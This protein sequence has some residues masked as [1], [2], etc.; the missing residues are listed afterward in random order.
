MK[1]NYKLDL[2][3]KI[4]FYLVQHIAI[5]KLVYRKYKLPLYKIDIYQDKEKDKQE[6]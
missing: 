3:I 6:I 2:L 1:V 4:N 5:L